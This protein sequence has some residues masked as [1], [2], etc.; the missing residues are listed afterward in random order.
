MTVGALG[1]LEKSQVLAV[2]AVECFHGGR[3]AAGGV[4]Q[5]RQCALLAHA[6]E[7]DNHEPLQ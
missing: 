7:S 2:I 1:I 3:A 6:P 4:G 5:A